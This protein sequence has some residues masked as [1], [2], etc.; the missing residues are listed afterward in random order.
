MAKECCA[1]D[2]PQG[3]LTHYQ[4]LYMDGLKLGSIVDGLVVGSVQTLLLCEACWV[5][6]YVDE[7]DGL[8]D[9]EMVP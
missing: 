4:C 8:R 5:H 7:S 3:K 2:E 9:E 6:I 1:C